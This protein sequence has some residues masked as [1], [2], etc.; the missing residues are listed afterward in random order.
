MQL[1][2]HWRDWAFLA[3]GAYLIIAGLTAKTLIDEETPVTEEERA[4]AKATPL[5]RFA[6]V[7]AGLVAFVY[8]AFKLYVIYRH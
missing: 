1:I 7:G 3:M 8:S 2:A 4:K 6:V 5:K